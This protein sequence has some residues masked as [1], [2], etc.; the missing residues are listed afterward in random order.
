MSEADVADFDLRKTIS[1]AILRRQDWA[2][3]NPD[4]RLNH[5]MEDVGSPADLAREV[6]HA[7][8]E[9]GYCFQKADGP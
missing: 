7:L 8:Y 1:A 9:A 4:Q 6:T 3:D 5:A 2:R